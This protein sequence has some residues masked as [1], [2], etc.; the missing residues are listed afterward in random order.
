MDAYEIE[1]CL[2]EAWHNDDIS[3]TDAKGAGADWEQRVP[4][5]VELTIS[6]WPEISEAA[7]AAITSFETKKFSYL[8]ETHGTIIAG[9]VLIRAG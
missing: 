8:H 4:R 1:E 6:K 5:A 2:V 7:Q 3:E 9:H